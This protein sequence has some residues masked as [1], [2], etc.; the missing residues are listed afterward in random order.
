VAEVWDADEE[1]G[2]S[3]MA[4]EVDDEEDV[5]GKVDDSEGADS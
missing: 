2:R 5:E 3:G 1:S 4:E